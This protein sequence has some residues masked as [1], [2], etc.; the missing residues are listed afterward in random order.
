VSVSSSAVASSSATPEYVVEAV[1]ASSAIVLSSAT[2]GLVAEL[3][4]ASS[5]VV[6]GSARYDDEEM[7]VWSINAATKAV[8]RY[9]NFDFNSFARV[10]NK[11]Y[12]FSDAGIFE[13]GGGTDA[14]QPIGVFMQSGTIREE[15]GRLMPQKAYL[16]GDTSGGALEF[17]ILD[18]EDER[19]DYEVDMTSGRL[20]SSP[21][22]LG[23]GIRTRHLRYGLYGAITGPLELSSVMMVVA[24]SVRNA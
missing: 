11:L 22:V 1:A 24:P 19:Y 9:V 20:D 15:S 21:V 3:V 18:D 14:G 2:A 17:F 7:E 5:A 12:G 16:V 8:G 4:A 10:G 13:I 6:Y 23:K